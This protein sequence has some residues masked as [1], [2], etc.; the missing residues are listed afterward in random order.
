MHI[1]KFDDCDFVASNDG[2][3]A[4]LAWYKKETGVEVEADYIET[5]TGEEPMNEAE[6]GDPPMMTTMR[7]SAQKRIDAGEQLPFV[8]GVDAHYI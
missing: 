6:Q 4:T 1:W 8:I 5:C 2:L 7:E 3:E